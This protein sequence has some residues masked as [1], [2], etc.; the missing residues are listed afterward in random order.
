METTCGG[1][2]H[3]PVVLYGS[4]GRADPAF[5]ANWAKLCEEGNF[6]R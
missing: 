3:G 4:Y 1:A 2:P 6:A 5:A